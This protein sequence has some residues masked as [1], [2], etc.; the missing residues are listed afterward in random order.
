VRP[1]EACQA[2]AELRIAHLQ[3]GGA[4]DVQQGR[5]LLQEAM[6]DAE[7]LGMTGLIAQWQD[8]LAVAAEANV[9]GEGHLVCMTPA[10]HGGWRVA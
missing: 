10:P 3:R 4:G 8:A 9:A 2:R 5:A 7:V 6:G 1:G